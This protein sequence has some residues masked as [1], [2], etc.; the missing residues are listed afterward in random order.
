MCHG[1]ARRLGHVMIRLNR[2]SSGVP[3]FR[4]LY[5]GYSAWQMRC[6]GRPFRQG[7]RG[8]R[9]LARAIDLQCLGLGRVKAFRT[10]D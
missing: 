2:I 7:L 5:A 8:F 6:S 1:A 9:A 4:K 3:L 10:W